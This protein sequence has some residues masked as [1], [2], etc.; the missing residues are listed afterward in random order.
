MVY[1]YIVAYKAGATYLIAHPALRTKP[2]TRGTR[3]SQLVEGALVTRHLPVERPGED[4]PV[5]PSSLGTLDNA[6]LLR[7]SGLLFAHG[8]EFS[9][10]ETIGRQLLSVSESATWWIAD[11]IAYGEKTF[12]DRYREAIQQTSLNYQTLRN[13]V[14]VARRFDL[15]RRRDTL[16]FGHHAEVAALDQPEQDYW[17]RKAEEHTWSRNQLRNEVRNSLR[18]RQACGESES[19]TE[20]NAVAAEECTDDS[21]GPTAPAAGKVMKVLSLRLTTRQ[22][23]QFMIAAH[24]QNQELEE[25][26]LQVLESLC[27]LPRDLL[28]LPAGNFRDGTGQACPVPA[29]LVPPAGQAPTRGVVQDGSSAAVPPLR[30]LAAIGRAGAGQPASR[31]AEIPARRGR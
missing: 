22:F 14:W 3:S 18:L 11:W 12:H 6:I 25:W 5:V 1:F 19:R 7:R 8:V 21:E 27:H 13:Y 28:A 24:S 15:S 17:L 29:L 4:P 9:K 31:S 26:A 10:W 20:R 23:E 2:A 30:L 16:S